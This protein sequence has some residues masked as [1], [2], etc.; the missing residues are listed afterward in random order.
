MATRWRAH[1]RRRRSHPAT[2]TTRRTRWSPC[3][4]GPMRVSFPRAWRDSN[5]QRTPVSGVVLSLVFGDLSLEKKKHKKIH[6]VSDFW[7]QNITYFSNTGCRDGNVPCFVFVGRFWNVPGFLLWSHYPQRI[8][9]PQAQDTC[10]AERKMAAAQLTASR[11]SRRLRPVYNL[12]PF[13]HSSVE[14]WLDIKVL[15]K[16]II[17]ADFAQLLN[18]G[19]TPFKGRWSESKYVCIFWPVKNSGS[20]LK[21]ESSSGRH[22]WSSWVWLNYIYTWIVC[23]VTFCPTLQLVHQSD[24]LMSPVT[25]MSVLS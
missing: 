19:V 13:L 10:P 9:G 2:R 23:A 15:W 14:A 20:N 12:A 8:Q 6:L 7:R 24:E 16:W 21:D 1:V 18:L 3:W 5:P 25:L 4:T 17:L 22:R 11:L